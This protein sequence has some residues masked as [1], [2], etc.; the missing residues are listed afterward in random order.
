MGWQNRSINKTQQGAGYKKR[1]IQNEI[2]RLKVKGCKT[3]FHAM[4]TKKNAEI[5]VLILDEVDFKPK[6]N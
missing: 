6:V 1:V 4:R 5:A 2:H 3:A